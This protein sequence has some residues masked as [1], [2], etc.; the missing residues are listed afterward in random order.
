METSNA[1]SSGQ[2]NSP[3]PSNRSIRRNSRPLAAC[4]S[5]AQATHR[6]QTNSSSMQAKRHHNNAFQTGHSRRQSSPLLQRQWTIYSPAPK[7]MTFPS[8]LLRSAI[9]DGD[10]AMGFSCRHPQHPP[11]TPHPRRLAPGRDASHS[12]RS[13]VSCCS[14]RRAR[15]PRA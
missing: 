10:H 8:V 12:A 2:R 9:D 6:W 5:T 1:E 7:P 3:Y 11:L 4:F 15:A 14:G 13:P